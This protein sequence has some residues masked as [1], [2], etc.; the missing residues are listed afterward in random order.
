MKKVLLILLPVLFLLSALFLVPTQAKAAVSKVSFC[1]VD[2]GSP[3]PKVFKMRFIGTKTK[4]Y[5]YVKQISYYFSPR[6]KES[7]R[8]NFKIAAWD[9]RL[10]YHKTIYQSPDY[11]KR[12][13]KFNTIKLKKKTKNSSLR[14]FKIPRYKSVQA[15]ASFDIKADWDPGCRI[16]NKDFKI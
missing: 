15:S 5:F 1:V 12:N 9:N 8:N 6:D 13:S 3:S 7:N 4:D 16:E 10:S 11:L 2:K 14:Q